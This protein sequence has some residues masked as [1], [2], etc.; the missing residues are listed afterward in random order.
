[1]ATCLKVLQKRGE[2]QTKL[3][4]NYWGKGTLKGLVKK[5][6]GSST[7]T[8]KAPAGYTISPDGTLSLVVKGDEALSAAN[9]KAAE[10]QAKLNAE[11]QAAQDKLGLLTGK[12]TPHEVAMHEA[13]AHAEEYKLQ[14]AALNDE[15][16]KLSADDDLIAVLGGDPAH[17]AK[18]VQ[19]KSQISELQNKA[20]ISAMDDAQAQLNTTWTGMIDSVWDELIT[21]ANDTQHELQQIATHTV[22]SLNSEMAKAMTGQRVN[23]SGVF[24]GA[25]QGLAKTSLQTVEGSIIKGLG[26][27]GGKAKA[28][29]YHMWVDNLPGAT[30]SGIDGKAAGKAA[31][32]LLGML[33]DSDW[34]SSLFGGKLFGSGSFFGGHFATGGDVMGGVPI[35]VGEL[36]PERF[37][38]PSN[39][40]IVPTKDLQSSPSIGY[41]DA[42][43]TDPALT[44]ENFARALQ[45][46]HAQ[47]VGDAQRSMADRTR[48]NPQ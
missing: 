9:A 41:I 43:G 36:G 10:S 46:T 33:N 16:T 11:W 40:R 39:G 32:G 5:D 6:E 7:E 30:G 44:R 47:A 23:F 35:D 12:I 15:L 21:K 24:E 26:L 38:P 29:G 20:K 22:D 42:R 28:D 19:I 2:A 25:A 45:A 34:A 3:Y 48:R 8:E 14:L 13:A 17:A 1:M 27:G 4:E 18:E 31:G 37:V